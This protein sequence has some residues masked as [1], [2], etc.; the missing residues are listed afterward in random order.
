MCTVYGIL[1]TV[2]GV[3]GW[4]LMSAQDGEGWVVPQ[5]LLRHC[6]EGR[7]QRRGGGRVGDRLSEKERERELEQ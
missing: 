4:G 3:P 7:A 6:R 5:Y 2:C 1:H